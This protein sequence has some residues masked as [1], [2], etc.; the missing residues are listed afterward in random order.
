MTDS[1]LQ[2]LHV[3]PA[4]AATAATAAAA[5]TGALHRPFATVA[6]AI[7]ASRSMAKPVD[8]LLR[9]GTHFVGSTA[10]ELGPRDSGIRLANFPGEAAALSGG[11]PLDPQWAPSPACG[12]GCFEAALP[13]VAAI[14]GLRRDGVRE[15]RARWPNFDEE[16]DSVDENGVY[17]VHNGR[18]GWVTTETRWSMNG[19]DMNGIAGPWPPASNPFELHVMGAAD[20]PGVE[21]PMQEMINTSNGASLSGFISIISTAFSII[22]TVL[23]W[24][25]VG[26]HMCGALPSPVCA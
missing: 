12:A 6:A 22:S 15:I 20:W 4:A 26:I 23:S 18:D 3:D 11:V 13:S 21:W 7:E 17:N 25:C 2:V 14:P 10:L 1:R 9:G 8:I 16:L 19:T 24:I 5:A